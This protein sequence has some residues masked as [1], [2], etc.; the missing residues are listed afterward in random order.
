[1]SKS[2]L[3]CVLMLR[4]RKKIG[5]VGS[6]FV[7]TVQVNLVICLNNKLKMFIW[8]PVLGSLPPSDAASGRK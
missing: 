5:V 7:W 3:L 4:D 1:M 8:T 6:V 2:K